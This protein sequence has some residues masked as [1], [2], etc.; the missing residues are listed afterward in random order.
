MKI[1][2]K[3]LR[4]ES[5]EAS[6]F[7]QTF[8]Y[9]TEDAGATVAS[10]LEDLNRREPLTDIEGMPSGP[11]RW[12]CSCLQRKCGACAML[13]NDMPALACDARLADCGTA[14]ELKPLEK[15]PTVAD[16]T[17]DKSAAFESLKSMRVWLEGEGRTDEENRED[18]ELASQCLQCGLCLEICTSYQDGQDFYGMQALVPAARILAQSKGRESLP[19]LERYREHIYKGCEGFN[20][21]E[22]VCPAKIPVTEL[23]AHMN[24]IMERSLHFEEENSAKGELK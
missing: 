23:M 15:F 8:S 2:L 17:V 4:R 1:Q 6:A 19:L 11:I 18:A 7:W 3:I 16:L 20:A 13:V 12:E 10:A 21:C 9:E 5:P 14:V 22:H 24:F